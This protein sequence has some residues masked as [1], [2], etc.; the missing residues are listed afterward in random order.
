MFLN[1]APV[2]PQHI[3]LENI[4]LKFFLANTTAVMQPLDQGIIR[5]F[6][7]HYRR[8]LV[9]HVIANANA[10]MIA[11]DINITALDAVNWI[12]S[13]W[14]AVTESSIKNKFRFAAFEK[15]CMVHGVD[16]S[17]V[18]SDTN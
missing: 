14:G 15:V 16:G 18:N 9:K 17:S 6:K 13:A 10:A 3:E 11:D 12:D 8:C 5:T 4:K 7:A 1:N 2:H